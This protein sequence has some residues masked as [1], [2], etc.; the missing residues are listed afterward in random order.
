MNIH[1]VQIPLIT[2]FHAP[3]FMDLISCRPRVIT[4]IKSRLETVS[5]KQTDLLLS[6]Y[7]VERINIIFPLSATSV[8]VSHH[9]IGRSCCHCHW[10]YFASHCQRIFWNICILLENFKKYLLCLLWYYQLY[11]LS[12]S[13]STALW[14]SQ[15]NI[16]NSTP[17]FC[18]TMQPDT[19]K[20]KIIRTKEYFDCRVKR[21]W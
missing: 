4:P 13:V 2:V 19:N 21:F 20:Q 9:N 8:M 17:V 10:F 6:K 16:S 18:I 5:K 14:F 7:W 12:L 3:L 15:R 11:D 1:R